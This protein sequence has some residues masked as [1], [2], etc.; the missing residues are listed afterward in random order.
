MQIKEN[1]NKWRL[2]V[3]ISTT[4][5]PLI[6]TPG[7]YWRGTLKRKRNF[8]EKGIVHMKFQNFGIFFSKITKK[9]YR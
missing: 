9:Y 6:S 7:V 3:H 8:K 1:P 4:L 5:L 2:G